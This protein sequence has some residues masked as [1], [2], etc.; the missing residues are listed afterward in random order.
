MTKPKQKPAAKPKPKPAYPSAG[1]GG[2]R[3]PVDTVGM[4]PD[5]KEALG[6][7]KRKKKQK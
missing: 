5:M 2:Y 6:F 3:A 7:G 1:V 4:D